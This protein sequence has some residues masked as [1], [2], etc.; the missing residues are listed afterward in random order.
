LAP[1]NLPVQ[2]AYRED[3]PDYFA[4]W[5]RFGVD[6]RG[7]C[8]AYDHHI[9]SPTVDDIAVTWQVAQS[10]GLK[11]LSYFAYHGDIREP[12]DPSHVVGRYGWYERLLKPISVI[13]ESIKKQV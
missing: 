1:T 9:G 2:I 5:K 7:L 4:A 8:A 12:H 3:I 11:G 13:A 6:V 10:S